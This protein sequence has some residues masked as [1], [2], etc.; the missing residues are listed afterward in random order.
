MNT[1]KFN[2]LKRDLKALI[3]RTVNNEVQYRKFDK[4]LTIKDDVYD[5]SICKKYYGD[6]SFLGIVS[7]CVSPSSFLTNYR[8]GEVLTEIGGDKLNIDLVVSTTVQECIDKEV[9]ED[10]IQEDIE[11]D[12]LIFNGIKY[13]VN[14]VAHDV[15]VNNTPLVLNVFGERVE[16]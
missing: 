15:Y 12:L 2:K 5:E 16:K 11:D 1:F 9:Y 13:R 3:E 7:P 8:Y 6:K 14:K 10:L 4:T